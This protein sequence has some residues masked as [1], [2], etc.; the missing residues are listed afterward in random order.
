MFFLGDKLLTFGDLDIESFGVSHDAID[1]QF[2]RF[3]K[4]W[5]EFRYVDGYGLCF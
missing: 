3:M 4:D 5:K 2:Y 1:P